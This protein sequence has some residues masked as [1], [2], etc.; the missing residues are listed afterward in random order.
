VGRQH[1]TF[2]A[3]GKY[4][5]L[6]AGKMKRKR[7]KRKGKEGK[8]KRGRKRKREDFVLEQG[9]YIGQGTKSP[10]QVCIVS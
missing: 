2:A 1:E 3:I 5:V 9:S 8:R 7:E 4:S 10:F 6:S